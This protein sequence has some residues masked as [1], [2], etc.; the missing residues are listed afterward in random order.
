MG[1]Y[2]FD[3]L[4]TTKGKLKILKEIEEIHTNSV[5]FTDQ[6]TSFKSN[7]EEVNEWISLEE[8]EP[9]KEVIALGY[10]DEMLIGWISGNTCESD[11]EVLEEVTH[12]RPKPFS[13]NERRQVFNDG[14]VG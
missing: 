4:N 6:S 3:T 10:Q 11:G 8:H 14:A 2:V 9:N 7:L 5:R 13:I 1:L 12:W